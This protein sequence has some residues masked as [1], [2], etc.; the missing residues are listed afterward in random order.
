[1]DSQ[2]TL[3]QFFRAV[4]HELF[5]SK[6]KYNLLASIVLLSLVAVGY[7]WKE[8]Y[9]SY[10]TITVSARLLNNINSGSKTDSEHV[11]HVLDIAD[12]HMFAERMASHFL[13][14]SDTQNYLSKEELINSFI[15]RSNFSHEGSNIVVLS[16]S[17]DNPDEALRTLQLTLQ[18]LIDISVPLDKLNALKQ[19]YQVIKESQAN[20][21]QELKN[22]KEQIRGLARAVNGSSSRSVERIRSIRESLQDV[23]VNIS[24]VNAKIDRIR[25]KLKLEEELQHSKQ[26]LNE[27]LKQQQKIISNLERNEE[28]Y[29]PTSSEIVSLQQELDSVNV[30][31]ASLKAN[32]KL[33]IDG[34]KTLY[35]QL[36]AQETLAQVEIVSLQSRKESLTQLIANEEEKVAAEL[37]QNSEV[38]QYQQE[39][40]LITSEY[41]GLK[42]A[43]AKN[44]GMQ[45]QIE[46]NLPNI[47]VL[48]EP[49]LPE[50][51]IG[52]GFI[53]FLIMGPIVAFLLPLSIAAAL[54]LTD[55][56]IRTC[57]QLKS[58]L[59]SS[60]KLLGVIPH[61]DSPETLRV[62]REA[63]IGLFAWGVFVFSVYA[64]IGVIGLK[65]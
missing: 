50:E 46:K 14:S 63:V 22:K 35:E 38:A 30:K 31:I 24:A 54:V 43:R 51:Y 42:A 47:V 9:T 23:D 44:L 41:D 17:A 29:S 12:S 37:A 64:T 65:G 53:E 11:Q 16:Y 60:V 28:I 13:S 6:N 57:N 3:K 10:A 33:Y 39:Y 34:S 1:M 36:R 40:E 2:N 8:S 25:D 32:S 26:Q 20:A 7:F 45:Q 56:R 62:F 15:D 27:L 18:K 19:K 61:H 4:F 48:E 49:S 59:P 5:R 21:K 52:L 58:T 55:S